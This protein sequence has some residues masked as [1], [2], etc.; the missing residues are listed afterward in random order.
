M[1]D[2]FPITIYHNPDCGTSRTA[3]ALIEAAG[4]APTIID[5]RQAGWT[6]PLLD[7]LLAAMAIGPRALLRENGTPAASLGLLDRAASDEA[8]ITGMLAHPILV[9]RPIVVSP[10]GTRLCRPSEMVL[11]LLDSPPA[12]ITTP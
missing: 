8:I 11:N 3:L 5:Y 1:S 12:S 4:H 7:Q 10:K 6:R 2:A 9:N